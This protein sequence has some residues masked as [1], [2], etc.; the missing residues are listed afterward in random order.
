MGHEEGMERRLVVSFQAAILFSAELTRGQ[1]R[2]KA[3][4]ELC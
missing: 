3:A 4:S 1:W 2:R